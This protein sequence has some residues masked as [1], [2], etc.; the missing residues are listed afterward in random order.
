[1]KNFVAK[2]KEKKM[3]NKKIYLG[4]L[5]IVLA[6]GMALTGCAT[7]DKDNYGSFPSISVP[8]K[9][10]TSL[11]LVFS[12]AVIENNKGEVFTY[13]ALMKKAKELGADSIVNVTIDA[14]YEGTKFFGLK[15]KKKEL[16]YGSA[17]AIKYVAGT[18]KTADTTTTQSQAGNVTKT[19]EGV[20]MSGGGG[21]GGGGSGVSSGSSD[22]GG[23]SGTKWYNPFTWFK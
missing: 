22:N 16:W 6:L 21:G 13:Y 15:T 12:E 19:T 17:T 20:V 8:A 3:A 4:M 2:V 18:L 11:G 14:Q 23:S 1:M 9:D 10:F 7:I 5:I